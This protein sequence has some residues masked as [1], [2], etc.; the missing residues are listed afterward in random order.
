MKNIFLVLSLFLITNNTFS[1][2]TKTPT[3][4]EQSFIAGK[5]TVKYMVENRKATRFPKIDILS[6]DRGT[7]VVDIYVDKYGNVTSA[8][9]NQ[10]LSDTKS[11]YLITKSKQA[12][13]TTHFD[14]TPTTPLKTKGTMTFT[15]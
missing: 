6:D 10:S 12:A 14:S 13:E 7:I 2:E 4:A 3:V 1:Q 15:F 5:Y 11:N 8:T 9:P